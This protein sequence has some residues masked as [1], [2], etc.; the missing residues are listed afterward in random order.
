MSMGLQN[1]Y[2]LAGAQ[3]ALRQ[4]VLDQI[5]QAKQEQDRL[6]QQQ[7]LALR[8][9]HETGLEEDRKAALA[10]RIQLGHE[11][12]AARAFPQLP[13]GGAIDASTY[14]DTYKGT[15]YEGNFDPERTLPAT[16]LTGGLPLP[17]GAPSGTGMG[18][19]PPP[20]S[21]SPQMPPLR[22]QQ[23]PRALTG[24]MVSQGTPKMQEDAVQKAAVQRLLVR[25]PKDSQSAAAVEYEAATGKNAPAS[26]FPKE[27]PP[28][29][30]REM[31]DG[32]MRV[33][34]DNTTT[35]I[36][37]K[38]YHA[39]QQP[40]VLNQPGQT[41][42][43]VNRGNGVATPIKDASGKPL[44]PSVPAALQQ[45]RTNATNVLSH[46]RDVEREADEIN[47][48]G[49]MGPVGG[50]WADFMAGRIGAGE[51]AAGD[52][53]KAELLGA[54]R[55]DVGLLKSGMAMVHGGA[56]GGGSIGMA[57]RMDALINADKMDLPLFKGATSS[58][59]KWLTQYAGPNAAK[60][61]ADDAGPVGGDAGAAPAGLSYQDYLNSRKPK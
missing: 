13:L 33:N 60:D 5:A 8:V 1:A 37:G 61:L 46:V 35:P 51:L 26:L 28:G 34:P 54:F 31:A 56:R 27:A 39:P 17:T 12:T 19:T 10:E 11:T 20:E 45:Q 40:I 57:A 16:R 52:P 21:A 22:V 55:T 58:F 49:L 50:R 9:R 53:Q 18:D 4:R 24:R 25:L 6:I 42:S 3:S 30:I 38:P 47:K 14:A 23:A 41:P 2:G 32:F 59:R 36:P 29:P 15:A 48:L 44:D 43:L 7:E